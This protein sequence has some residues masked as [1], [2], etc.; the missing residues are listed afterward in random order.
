VRNLFNLYKI[1]APVVG[2]LL[3][4][5]SFV[6]LPMKYL[7]T[8]GS[9]LHEVG[10]DLSIGWAAHGFVYI[11]YVLV[12]LLIAYQAKWSVQ[13]LVLVLL[14]GLIPLIIFWVERAVSKKL[15]AQYP[16]LDPTAVEV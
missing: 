6:V 1:L 3:T 5:L 10:V 2:I 9:H 15:I 4:L 11:A 7:S 12:V 8:D 13:F 16:E 14:A